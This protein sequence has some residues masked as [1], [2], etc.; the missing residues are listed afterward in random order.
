MLPLTLDLRDPM[1]QAKSG[2]LPVPL[3][4]SDVVM[5]DDPEVGGLSCVPGSQMLA[6]LYDELSQQVP[7]PGLTRLATV[8]GDPTAI[9]AAGNRFHVRVDLAD[10]TST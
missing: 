3:S 1:G 5:V 7:P 9:D 2:Q 6:V 4:S 8:D 10:A